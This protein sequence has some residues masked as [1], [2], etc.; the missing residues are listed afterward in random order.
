ML[1]INCAD[2]T[3]LNQY[4]GGCGERTNV[5]VP[6]AYDGEMVFLRFACRCAAAPP[7]Y[8]AM[9]RSNGAAAM[10]NL[11]PHTRTHSQ[12]RMHVLCHRAAHSIK[13][14]NR[15][16]RER[17]IIT[18]CEKFERSADAFDENIL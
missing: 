18:K 12:T 8:V 6:R 14:N 9:G 3:A 15:K 16:A 5:N 11:Y 2:T 17:E 4:I 7:P 1:Q 10:Q 13:K